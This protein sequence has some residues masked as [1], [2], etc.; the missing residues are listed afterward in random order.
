MD[1]IEDRLAALELLF[2]ELAADVDSRR[3]QAARERIA[4]GLA[5]AVD[6]RET[7]IRRQAIQHLDE[8]LQRHDLFTS[9][10]LYRPRET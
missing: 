4:E 1:E 7:A 2:A 8:A 5:G 9:G 6:D 3:L 10:A